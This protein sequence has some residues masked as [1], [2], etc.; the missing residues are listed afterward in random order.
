M[1]LSGTLLPN[2]NSS[3]AA[4]FDGQQLRHH[5]EMGLHFSIAFGSLIGA[6]TTVGVIANALVVLAVLGDRKMRK[7]PMNLLLLNLV[8]FND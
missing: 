5:R 2:G 8:K 7:S 1:N 6:V 4:S 3:S